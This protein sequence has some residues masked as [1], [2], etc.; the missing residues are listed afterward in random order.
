MSL[1][2]KTRASCSSSATQVTRSTAEGWTMF[3]LRGVGGVGGSQSPIRTRW[4]LGWGVVKLREPQ[5]KV[6]LC[7]CMTPTGPR[8]E[9]GMER[10]GLGAGER[11]LMGQTVTRVAG[12]EKATAAGQDRTVFLEVCQQFRTVRMQRDRR[13]KINKIE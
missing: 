4:M 9:P 5:S 8:P 3:A 7:L 11:G 13:R 2:E 12:G 1:P 6:S 10:W